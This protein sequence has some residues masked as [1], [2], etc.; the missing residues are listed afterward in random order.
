MKKILLTASLCFISGLLMSQNETD[1]LRYS[2]IDVVGTARYQGL[3]GAFTALGVDMTT[4]ATNPAGIA[5]NRSSQFQFSPAFFGNSA[6][7]NLNG[8]IT[9]DFKLNVNIGSWGFIGTF[10]NKWNRN[11]DANKGFQSFSIGITYTRMGNFHQN[12]FAENT[13]STSSLLDSYTEK[14]NAGSGTTEDALINSSEFLF[15]ENLAYQTYLLNPDSMEANKYTSVVQQPGNTQT[16]RI[17]NY[18][19][20]G[21]TNLSF[22]G[23]LANKLYLGFGFGIS[24]IRYT[25]KSS[26]SEADTKKT[27]SGFDNF[28]LS[29]NVRTQGTGYNLK[30]GIIYHPIDWFR[31]G[32]SVI[33]PTFYQ[34]SDNYSTSLFSNLDSAAYQYDSPS[35][36]YNYSLFTAP[37]FNGGLAFIIG[38]F[39]L[40]SADYEFI[41][42]T[43]SRFTANSDYSFSTENQNTQNF[44]RPIGNVR[45]GT[46]WK[47]QNMSIRGGA[48]LFGNPYKAATNYFSRMNY[49][50]GIGYRGKH[51]FWDLTYVYGISTSDRALYELNSGNGP[52]ASIKNTTGNAIATFGIKF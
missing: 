5:G 9:S 20:I 7:S 30:A 14:L 16:L 41:Y 1:A 10:P 43:T 13:A 52:T 26:Y 27:Y 42:Y 48:V 40:I 51:F 44:L 46:E 50:L 35:G 37:R 3:G 18:G 33:S 23:N 28:T 49:S 4:A 19:R 39:G 45:V 31:V 47:I 15:R 17:E 2:A 21:E 24:R 38:K 12:L 22:G 8:N 32:A 29:D 36:T 11:K 6:S 25:S 34:L